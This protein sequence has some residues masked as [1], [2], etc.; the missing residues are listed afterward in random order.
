MTRFSKQ[1]LA[2][3]QE[4]KA[5]GGTISGLLSKKKTGDVS[6]KDPVTTLP[7]THSSAKHPAFPTLSLEM[8][9]SSGEEIRKKKKASGKSFLLTFWDDVDVAA[10]KAHETLS[11]D[12]LSP[13]MAKSS[14]EAL[15]ESLFIF[16][17][18]LDLEKKVATFE[19]LVKS[20]SAENEM[21]K[22]KVTILTAKAEND[23][24]HM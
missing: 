6:K 4:K 19:P 15:G 21:L 1:K 20:L 24:E 12:D 2:K 22:N 9:A 18:L 16:G 11:M 13:L 14:C 5:K 7:P 8:T 3:A 23:K 10:L 17:K